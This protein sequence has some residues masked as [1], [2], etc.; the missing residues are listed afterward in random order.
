MSAAWRIIKQKHSKSAFTGEGARLYGGR[1]NSPGT[2]MVYAA[3]SQALAVLEMLIHLDSSEL[4]RKYLLFEVAMDEADVMD[5]DR[6]VLPRN[7]KESPPPA[8]VQR[9]GDNWVASEASA[10]LRVPSTLV[11]GE[12][13]FLLNPKHKNFRRLKIGKPVSFHFDARLNKY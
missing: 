6:S 10:V 9:I 13:N 3:E 11:P 2:A 4:L 7:W 12:C 1:W 5:L 8:H